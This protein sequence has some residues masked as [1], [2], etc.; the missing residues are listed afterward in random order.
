LQ[1]LSE[2]ILLLRGINV[3]GKNPLPMKE[4]VE[5]LESLGLQHVRTYIQSGNAAFRAPGE[6]SAT[7][8]EEIGAAIEERRGFRP[9]VML[10]SAERLER[11]IAAN[12]YREEAEAE[13]KSVHLFFLATAPEAPDLGAMRE[14]RAPGER[15]ELAGDVF[16][17][18]AP[19]GVGRSKLAARAERLL[20]VD[21]TARNWRTVLKLQEMTR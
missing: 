3:G 19:A 8:G 14:I 15:C 4:L 6:V 11:A 1:L 5:V 18:H 12:P 2:W 13:P 21:A 17:L 9:C 20:G 16:Y 10:L 7:A